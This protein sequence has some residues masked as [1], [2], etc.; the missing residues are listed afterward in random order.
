MRF[1]LY[2]SPYQYY[3]DNLIPLAKYLTENGHEVFASYRLSETGPEISMLDGMNVDYSTKFL[4]N[5]LHVNKVILVQTWWYTDQLIAIKTRKKNL[6]LYVIDH[7]PP[8]MRF[9]QPDGRLSHIYR[10]D[11]IGQHYISWGQVTKDIMKQA[12]YKGKNVVLGSSR[13]E[14]VLN[15]ICKNKKGFVLY[16]TSARMEDK[17]LL[18]GFMKFVKNHSDDTFII[19]EHSR[20]SKIY[21]E[22]LCY[23]NVKL[24]NNLKEHELFEYS[25]FIFT[26]PSSAMLVPA[27]K[28][29][30][31]YALYD[32]HFCE[33]A[34]NYYK[35][36]KECIFTIKESG[37]PNYKNFIDSNILYK[38]E[39]ANQRIYK[40]IMG[41]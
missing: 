32:K 4:K 17:N 9:K 26:F 40:Y 36:H 25:D 24:N 14:S 22:V 11:D 16:D 35:Q 12:G 33:A 3:A 2:S 41:N 15:N 1:F 21:R 18:S 28:N 27:L 31:M 5:Q 8:M 29:K 13:T 37:Q 7:A 20:S 38:D 30:M 23:N 6:D 10:G 39:S 34:R 19:Q